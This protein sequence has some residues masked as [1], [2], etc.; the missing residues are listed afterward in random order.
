MSRFPVLRLSLLAAA[1]L[2]V[3]DV[4]AGA[5]SLSEFIPTGQTI[6][7]TATPG[8]HFQP[9]N[10]GLAVLPDFTAGQAV[11]TAV[12]PDGKTLLV[13]TSGYN[14]EADGSGAGIPGA[15]NE[16]V[17]VFDISSG[18]PVQK[19]ALQLANTYVGLAFAPA[20][21]AFYVTGGQDD[22]V[23]RF[24][25]A[26]GVW[27]QSAVV[28]LNN[29]KGLGLTRGIPALGFPATLPAQAAGVAVSADGKTVA[30]ANNANDS[31][32]LLDVASGKFLTFDL[33]P[34]KSDPAKVGVPGGEFP[35]WV[36]FKG[37][38]T[39]YVSSVR[40][41]EVVV[42]S[43]N[44][45]P[46]A[47]APSVTSRIALKG[48]PTKMILNHA[49]SRLMIASDNSDTVDIVDTASN[50]LVG[51]IDTT[52]PAG[53]VKVRRGS[54]PNSLALSPDEETLYVTNAGSNSVAVIELNDKQT[55]GKVDGLIPTGWY[56]NSVSV[57]ADGK[58]LY[59]VN[60]KSN[61]G[62]APEQCSN[63]RSG[64]TGDLPAN[65]V[66]NA[67]GC[68][69]ALQNGSSNTYVL[70]LTKAGLL[71]LPVPTSR[72]LDSLTNTVFANNGFGMELPEAAKSVVRGLQKN[73]Q[74]VIYIVKENRTYDQVLGDVKTGNGD[75]SIAQFPQAITP[76]QHAIASQFVLLDNFRTSGEVSMDGWQWSTAARSI[77]ANDKST[78][79]NYAGRGLTY[80]SEGTSRGINVALPDLQSR[81]VGLSVG[82]SNPFTGAKDPVTGQYALPFLLNYLNL[83]VPG[84]PSSPLSS[85]TDPDLLPGTANEVEM[86][87][88]G[89]EKAAG[90]IWNAALRAGKS[91]RNYG[92][93]LD[94]T[95]ENVP[96]SLGGVSPQLRDPH[97][98]G[99]VVA[100]PTSTD[101]PLGT[102]TDP[103]FRGFDNNF[104]D[105][106]RVR[107]WAREFD[108]YDASNT[109]PQLELV[110]V[111]HDHMGN[112]GSAIDGI[113]TPELQQ[114][115]NDYAVGLIAQKVA[116]SKNYAGNTLIFVLEDDSQDGPD[117]VD[118]HRS[119]AYIVGPYVKQGVTVS[120]EYTTVNMLRTIEDV[121]GLGH[122]NLH[123]EG[124]LP[125]TDVFDLKQ[126]T[127]S[128]K[129]VPSAYLYG[130]A[131]APLLP[132]APVAAADI[133]KP[134]H[135]AAWW[136]DKTRGMDFSVE[137]R[138]D[139][140][141][142]NRILWQGL[143][144]D[145]PYPGDVAGKQA[146]RS[147]V[148][149][150]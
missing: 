36:S 59:V 126:K 14:R 141:R 37:N 69:A 131:L 44:G 103:Y 88:P 32:S 128:Y 52:A 118:T 74:H 121:L 38:N 80:D 53:G 78:P 127:W 45:A 62:P 99:V 146:P 144:G 22:S 117:H 108:Q 70:Q 115:D 71:T 55:G 129:A 9:L 43:I 96:A 56:P 143:K 142:F 65:D 26:A 104:P 79:V 135:T 48:N 42:V 35:Y 64:P 21:D 13:L 89:G 75:A 27:S 114:A 134:T 34:G 4:P 111:M 17:F 145:T 148:L 93:F 29:G 101:L 25:Q 24:I 150:D 137:D 19:Q 12:S 120:T 130:T 39:V 97:A 132:T 92:F 133:P 82:A 138:I 20:G 125:M 77:D 66:V 47:G 1:L 119:T 30:V 102:V 106:W 49:Q 84:L 23:Y 100:S 10:P 81:A 113:N 54:S 124:A 6:T 110:R 123:D 15:S 91:V 50:Q 90:Y 33:R 40:D 94:L 139:A 109:L 51:S 28:Q 63:V 85:L 16:Y 72:A 147:Q 107:E 2:T 57:S 3:L 112:F 11:T 61:A 140:D 60:A 86:D 7:P 116:N 105:F 122:L 83:F 68:P 76:N 31:I 67:P 41:R 58:M 136:A 18:L 5:A 73:I 149:D 95:L 8:A 98:A 46:L 87:G